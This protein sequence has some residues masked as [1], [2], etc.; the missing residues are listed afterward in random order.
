[1]NEE[2]GNTEG[3]SSKM[4][5]GEEPAEG[6]SK[7]PAGD[8]GKGAGKEGGSAKPKGP[9]S[10]EAKGTA[11]TGTDQ[12]KGGSGSGTTT[13]DPGKR[14]LASG[15]AEQ[16]PGPDHPKTVQKKQQLTPGPD[17]GSKAGAQK[18][19]HDEGLVRCTEC[20]KMTP[21]IIE[22][23]A[24]LNNALKMLEDKE[25]EL[26]NKNTELKETVLQKDI[27]TKKLEETKTELEKT[28]EV[29]RTIARQKDNAVKEK[30]NAVK[31]LETKKTELT[32]L[33]PRLHLTQKALEVYEKRN[34]EQDMKEIAQRAR[35]DLQKLE[36]TRIK[37]EL[38]VLLR[39]PR[40]VTLLQQHKV[41]KLSGGSAEGITGLEDHRL[42][43]KYGKTPPSPTCVLGR[44]G[45]DEEDIEGTLE[46][47]GRGRRKGRNQDSGME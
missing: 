39:D 12:P 17:G 19:G 42:E 23:V 46:T 7:K 40:N 15:P 32:E 20:G 10:S 31:E 24:E 37:E 18:T 14:A 43:E 21:G 4:A 9:V 36:N 35:L 29:M 27:V 26:E 38:E 2:K 44:G 1:M 22:E 8:K 6:A 25:T 41:T 47:E 45:D 3:K 30:H 33:A 13:G 28:K 5:K 34:T 16:N 11:G